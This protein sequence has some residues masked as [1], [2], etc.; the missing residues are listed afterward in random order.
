MA[1]RL[2]HILATF[3]NSFGLKTNPANN[4]PNLYLFV[5]LSSF[6][7]FDS[8]RSCST[9]VKLY[10][11]PLIV[12][13]SRLVLFESRREYNLTQPSIRDSG[14]LSESSGFGMV[15]R[16]FGTS[17]NFTCRIVGEFF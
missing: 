3:A 9:P 11:V 2:Y 16:V 17:T 14:C 1:D 12:C 6:C 13:E 15:H 4:V 10:L 8:V 7:L 5:R